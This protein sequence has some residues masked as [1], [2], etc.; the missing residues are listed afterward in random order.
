MVPPVGEA[1]AKLGLVEHVF[2]AVLEFLGVGV[3][4]EKS[5]LFW[6]LSVQP[7]FKRIAA[8]ELVNAAT[9]AV[10]S[11]AVTAISTGRPIVFC[12]SEA[13]DNWQMFKS[14]AWFIPENE[15]MKNEVERLLAGIDRE[16][17]ESKA[18]LTKDIVIR[19]KQQVL[20]T[21]NQIGKYDQ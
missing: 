8:V 17:I 10:P 2:V 1:I 6:L 14:A 13:S 18:A 5:V 7:P 21:Y 20:N 9:A 11:K 15:Q 19:L 3:P 4:V 12:G 16:Q